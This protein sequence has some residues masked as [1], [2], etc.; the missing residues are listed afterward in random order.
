MRL[1]AGAIGAPA[2]APKK[3]FLIPHFPLLCH[4][5]LTLLRAVL[6]SV[7]SGSLARSRVMSHNLRE[8]RISFLLYKVLRIVAV[9][10]AVYSG[11]LSSYQP[12]K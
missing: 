2:G 5:A 10:A 8:V 9:V 12:S 3:H 6:S 4:L 11:N 1:L 7:H